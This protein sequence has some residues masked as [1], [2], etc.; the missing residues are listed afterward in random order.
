MS[1]EEEKYVLNPWIYLI[2]LI[3]KNTVETT[4]ER[5]VYWLYVGG[6][7]VERTYLDLHWEFVRHERITGLSKHDAYRRSM[8]VYESIEVML[9]RESDWI[10]GGRVILFVTT[11]K[12][13]EQPENYEFVFGD[14][15]F[16]LKRVIKI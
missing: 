1:L 11:M 3:M 14:D 7:P 2:S 12:H 8:S 6:V 15:Y 5:V 16:S 10:L 13:S 4:T 9:E